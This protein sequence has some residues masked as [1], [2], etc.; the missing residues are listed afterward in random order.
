MTG[1]DVKRLARGLFGKQEIPDYNMSFT[2]DILPLAEMTEA[3]LK[4][5]DS[6]LGL[7]AW[8]ADPLEGKFS[9]AQKYD[10]IIRAMQCGKEEAM[11]IRAR[12]G[13]SDPDEL[14]VLMG[15]KISEPRLPVGGGRVV[16]AQYT[17]PDEVMIF[18]DAVDR[19]EAL[20]Q[21]ENLGPLLKY[22]DIRRLLLAHELF[23]G[24][25][26]S[27]RETIYTKTEKVELWK[28]PFSN[29][30]GLICLGEIAG[31]A[32]AG[33]LLEMSC[34]PYIFDVVLMYG[35]NKEAAAVLFEEIMEL[36]AAAEA[37]GGDEC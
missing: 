11:L 21:E 17:E 25:E 1:A 34:S 14:A 4:L 3:L 18:M 20:I 7:Y 6:V 16:F 27:K 33:E 23:H 29:Q 26:Y 5:P 32:F 35:Y 36:A 37:D 22:T 12:Y 31:M 24:V 13:T 10:Y 15:L 19:A 30:S 8:T 9:I 2:G 28:K